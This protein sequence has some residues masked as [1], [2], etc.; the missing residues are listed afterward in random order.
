MPAGPLQLSLADAVRR[1]LQFNLGV[2]TSGT[3]SATARAQRAQAL[4]RLLPQV[5]ASAGATET[6]VNLAT[7]GFGGLA[8]PGS[9]L[10]NLPTV[11]GPF[12]YVQAQGNVNWNVFSATNLRNYG[13]L[14][15]A[16]RAANFNE[17]D[18][19][20]LVVLAVAGSYMQITASAARTESQ[21]TQVQYAQAIYDRSQTQLKAGT[22]IRVDVSR[23]L[24]QLQTEQERLLAFQAE[25]DQLKLAFARLIGAP[26]DH[27]IVFSEGLKY[28]EMPE[29]DAAAA[30]RTAFEGRWDLRAAQAQVQAAQRAVAAA[31]GE[32]LPTVAL[33]GYYGAS[34]PSP[35]NAHGVF[36]VTGGVTVPIFEGGRIRADIAQSE[37]TLHQR[38]AEYQDQ[39]GRVEQDVRNAL[40]Q[41]RTA[42]GQVRLAESN[43]RYALETL[44]QS[45]DRFEAGVTNTVEVVQAQ[46]QEAS[47]EN[48][49]ISSLFALNLARLGLARATGQAE[50]G[51]ANL[52]TGG[53]P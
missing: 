45:R 40:I 3:L 37:A 5:D 12:H 51:V 20:E 4:S 39:K 7:F 16:E 24:V 8:G 25:Y 49:Y 22:A 31:R 13:A 1:G 50:T 38:E 47:A 21:R 34:G 26:Q 19:R 9:P 36:E 11:V 53:R 48:D 2:I 10:G 23:S 43:R 33:N 27:E 35:T 52:F 30:L 41:I 44:T 17:R 28:K 32:R 14:Q 46:Q 42:T 6:Q 18:I 29:V 15:A